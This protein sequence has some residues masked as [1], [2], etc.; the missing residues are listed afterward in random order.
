MQTP[1]QPP[2][3]IPPLHNTPPNNNLPVT[4]IPHD[5]EVEVQQD[6]THLVN[7]YHTHVIPPEPIIATAA[8]E[9]I[10]YFTLTD[11]LFGAS[12]KHHITTHG[13]HPL[14]GLQLY[15]HTDTNILIFQASTLSTPL[16]RTPKWKT[17]LRDSV[18]I[19]VG[20]KLVSNIQDVKD[21]I[22]AF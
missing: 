20:N 21:A 1:T 6:F 5:N 17:E 10:T 9:Q 2:L 19:S 4:I 12:I 14:L 11:N 13:N 16:T 15:I 18:L 22:S 7:S 8:H 3:T